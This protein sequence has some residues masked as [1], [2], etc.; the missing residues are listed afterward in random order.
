MK[1]VLV[2][3]FVLAILV[4][5]LPV[6][7]GELKVSGELKYGFISDMDVAYIPVYGDTEM[8]FDVQ[9]DDFNKV[10]LTVT[11]SPGN[12][13]YGGYGM[14]NA[15][16]LAVRF[17]SVTTDLAK[18]MALKDV[19]ATLQTG[20]FRPQNERFAVTNWA[21]V[22]RAVSFRTWVDGG[23]DLTVGV[24]LIKAEVAFDTTVFAKDGLK[25]DKGL[26][27]AGVFGGV[28]PV[29][30]ELFYFNNPDSLLDDP[31]QDDSPKD[32]KAIGVAAKFVQ[33]VI[34]K[35]LT[36]SATA[37]FY[38]NTNSDAPDGSVWKYG[39]GAAADYMGMAY[40]NLAVNGTDNDTLNWLA[41]EVGG[42]YQKKVGG[43]VGVLTSFAE[44][45]DMFQSADLS[46]WAAVGATKF[47]L[48]YLI[49]DV[50]E[51]HAGMDLNA[52]STLKGYAGATGGLY[53][54]VDCVY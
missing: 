22:D 26:F 23:M 11:A 19:V 14:P 16:G 39:I 35:T 27:W 51:G 30:A 37:Q 24:P 45:A 32:V 9:V 50:D 7:A 10:N 29:S 20:F 4:L 1:K 13:A 36:A 46:A 34:P 41:I 21:S 42:N 33:E 54:T 52:P 12:E 31:A 40:G 17:F 53:L 47:R 3:T 38:Y 25:L 49:Q 18:Y 8:A 44:D 28:G 48:G 43:D 6:M 5:G 2:F 15:N